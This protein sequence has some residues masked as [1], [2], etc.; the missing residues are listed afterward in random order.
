[1]HSL[2]HPVAMATTL[3]HEMDWRH[4][5]V[6]ADALFLLEASGGCAAPLDRSAAGEKVSKLTQCF[7]RK[8]LIDYFRLDQFLYTVRLST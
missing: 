7:A 4:A 3:L 5:F 2:T 8:L 1:M 6:A